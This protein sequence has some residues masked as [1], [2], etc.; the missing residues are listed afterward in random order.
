MLGDGLP[1]YSV[2]HLVWYFR[3]NGL[4][5]VLAFRTSALSLLAWEPGRY[6][7]AGEAKPIKREKG[8]HAAQVPFRLPN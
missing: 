8:K 7:K 6:E 2:S 1:K 4:I 3:P 5:L